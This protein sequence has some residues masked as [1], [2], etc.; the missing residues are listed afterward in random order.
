[1]LTAASSNRLLIFDRIA[2]SVSSVSRRAFTVP[3][4]FELRP[5]MGQPLL[6]FS[7]NALDTLSAFGLGFGSVLSPHI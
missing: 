7:L 6:H 4:R 3:A 5:H 1:M 2:H